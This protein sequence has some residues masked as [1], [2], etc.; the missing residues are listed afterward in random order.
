MEISLFERCYLSYYAAIIIVSTTTVLT[1]RTSC[2]STLK[3]IFCHLCIKI[4]LYQVRLC[5]DLPTRL[6]HF[7][8]MIIQ[9]ILLIIFYK[10]PQKVRKVKTKVVLT[11]MRR[12]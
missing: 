10:P 7:M 2:G 11:M 5:Y 8:I 3:V 4:Y 1:L 6:H 12:F 9:Y